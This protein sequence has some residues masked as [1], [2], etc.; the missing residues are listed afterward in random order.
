ML[1]R[2]EKIAMMLELFPHLDH[3]T[4][5]A[6]DGDLSDSCSYDEIDALVD[7]VAVDSLMEFLQL[8]VDDLSWDTIHGMITF[9]GHTAI[10]NGEVTQADIED[11]WKN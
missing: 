11:Y 8:D 4:A 3:D 5:D 9:L 7:E 2:T 6:I 10:I 1:T